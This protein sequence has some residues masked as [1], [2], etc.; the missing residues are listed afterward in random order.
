MNSHLRIVIILC[1]ILIIYLTVK[2]NNKKNKTKE[3][4]NVYYV[5]MEE[6]IRKLHNNLDMLENIREY[7]YFAED[8]FLKIEDCVIKLKTHTLPPYETS[9]DDFSGII[10]SVKDLDKH[11]NNIR[12][13]VPM[14]DE[15]AIAILDINMKFLKNEASKIIDALYEY[16]LL[17]NTNCKYTDITYKQYINEII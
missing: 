13:T 7:K 9:K 16:K 6:N 4:N 14:N 17:T 10:K 3:L 12:K 2:Y 8:Q 11:W 5:I 15:E 1:I